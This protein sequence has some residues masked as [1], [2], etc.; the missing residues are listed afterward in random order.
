MEKQTK[1]SV[2]TVCRNAQ[3]VIE[4]TIQSVVEQNYPYVEYIIIDGA[5][6]DDTLH[7]IEKAIKGYDVTVVSEEDEGIY[8]AMNKGIA[9]AT[10]SFIQ[11]L[12]AGDTFID[13]GVL[14]KVAEKI[15]KI[16]GD[17][18]YGNIEYVYPDGRKER[19][20]YG[21]SCKK[22]SYF[23]LG[24]CIN[25][26]SIFAAANCLKQRNFD[27]T[28][29]ICADREW[30]MD[31]CLKKKNFVCLNEMICRYSLEENSASIKEKETYKK[32]AALCVKKYFPVG[33]IIYWMIDWIRE[34]PGLNHLLH[35]FY[36]LVF[37]RK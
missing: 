33:F 22:K 8:D 27:V 16:P 21:N 2:I 18:Y 12:N 30:M 34:T 19:R 1:F 28:Y 9:L 17:I 3:D 10:G 24:D 23:Y 35:Y 26:Q 25:H 37:I 36:R 15:G 6:Q 32:E 11:F 7:R 4:K 31:M 20:I 5:S 14:T 13:S 29:K